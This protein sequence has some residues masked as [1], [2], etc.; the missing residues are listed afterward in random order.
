MRSDSWEHLIEVGNP[1]ASASVDQRELDPCIFDRSGEQ[2][3]IPASPAAI[4]SGTTNDIRQ[5]LA[6]IDHKLRAIRQNILQLQQSSWLDS[7]AEAAPPAT[8]LSDE[9]TGAVVLTEPAT[10]SDHNRADTTMAHLFSTIPVDG[11]IPTLWVVQRIHA[12]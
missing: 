2:S 6:Q 9:E 10:T 3:A 4:A 5:K 8:D 11:S 7:L 12:A 1:V